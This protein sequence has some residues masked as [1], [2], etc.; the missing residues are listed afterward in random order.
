[1]D[2]YYLNNAVYLTQELLERADPPY[3]GEVAYG[4]RA[5]HCWN[6]D[7]TQPNAISRLR[8][9]TMYVPKILRT[10]M[11]DG[12]LINYTNHLPEHLVDIVSQQRLPAVWINTRRENSAVYPRN[13]EAARSLTN[14]LLE[15]GHRRGEGGGC[16]LVPQRLPDRRRDWVSRG[17]GRHAGNPMRTAATLG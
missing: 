6:G 4:D 3:G 1:M 16:G 11:A 17:M 14:R 2:N 12:L 5:E 10:L 15:L 13:F 9:N 8:Y 7:P